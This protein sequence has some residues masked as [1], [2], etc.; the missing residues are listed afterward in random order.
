MTVNYWKFNKVI[1]SIHAMVSSVVELIWL[2]N[3]M[4]IYHSV[5]DL[6]NAFFSINIALESQ[7]QFEFTWESQQWS[8]TVL[9]QGYL[10]I[11]TICHGLMVEDLAK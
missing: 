5:I 1:P 9:P 10:H 7:D 11:L 3:K 8:F 2:T 4:G 6:A